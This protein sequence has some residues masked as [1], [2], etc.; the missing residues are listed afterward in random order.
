[1]LKYWEKLKEKGRN[2]KEKVDNSQLNFVS[3]SQVKENKI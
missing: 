2:K 3:L 1:M